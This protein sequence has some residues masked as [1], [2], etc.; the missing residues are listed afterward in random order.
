MESCERAQRRRDRLIAALLALGVFGFMLLFFACVHPLVLHDG[1]DWG[2]S[3]YS[4]GALPIWGYWNPSRVLPEILSPACASAAA[5]LVMPL[6]G[7]F[8]TAY[9][10]LLAAAVSACITV[11]ALML[12]RLMQREGGCTAA[13]A[14]MLSA[15]FLVM[16]FLIFRTQ[17]TGNDHLLYSWNVNT[18]FFYT[19]PNLLNAALALMWAGAG[20]RALRPGGGMGQGFL[21]LAVYLAVFSNLFASQILAV[22]AFVTLALA[23]AKTRGRGAWR[24]TL[25]EHGWLLLVL[26]LWLTAA[27]FDM[28]GGRSDSLTSGSLMQRLLETLR[29]MLARAR[30]LNAKFVGVCALSLAGALALFALRRE[31]DERDGR[32]IALLVRFLLCAVCCGVCTAALCTASSPEYARRADVLFA[33]AFFLLAAVMTAL[34]YIVSR[35]P[36]VGMVLPLLCLV[37]I[38]ETDTRITTFREPNIDQLS[39][40]QCVAI[41]EAIMN[42]IAGADREGLTELAVEVPAGSFSFL[43]DGMMR[44]ML[45]CGLI[46]RYIQCTNVEIEDFCARYG[47]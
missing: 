11:Y 3:S 13:A 33:P 43:S 45:K 19:I 38:F 27:V 4:R 31:R 14:A 32:F 21:L 44:T 20:G 24:R 22:Y 6:T 5:Y 46:D 2:Y 36:H 12:M 29:G 47:I 10:L 7:S 39:P 37:L 26:A 28:N 30:M 8:N 18:Y 9:T 41:N 42:Q 25:G 23:L 17:K 1:D 35:A 34:A 15:L 16:H 40:K